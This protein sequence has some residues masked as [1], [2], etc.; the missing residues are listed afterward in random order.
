MSQVC[1]PN[2]LPGAGPLSIRNDYNQ[3]FVDTGEF[4]S[5]FLR[6]SDRQHR[7]V[8]YPRLDRL[9]GLKD[10]VVVCR[11]TPQQYLQ[12]DL[13][14]FDLTSLGTKFDVILV[15]P[16]WHEYRRRAAHALHAHED[17]TPWSLEELKKLRVDLICDTPSFLFLWAGS[18]H[19]EDARILLRHWGFRRCEDVCW[20]KTNTHRFSAEAE[21]HAHTHTH[22]HTRTRPAAPEGEHSYLHRVK[23]HCLVGIKGTVRRSTDG[24]FVHTNIDTDVLVGEESNDIA[25]TS[26]PMELYHLIEHF[27]LDLVVGAIFPPQPVFSFNEVLHIVC[28]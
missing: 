19:L 5:N 22:T 7:F 25:S 15:D 24:H 3:H 6:E 17:L 10:D 28:A 21:G 18:T 4:P 13:S 11:A 9:M 8:D 20:V 14:T 23:E 26:K 16:P 12:T 1:V 27:C 2:S